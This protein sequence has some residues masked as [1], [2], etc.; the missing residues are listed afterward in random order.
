MYDEKK[1]FKHKTKS[2]NKQFKKMLPANLIKS[3][4]TT[5]TSLK[6]LD[7]SKFLNNILFLFINI[8]F[9]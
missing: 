6:C 5:D 4:A 7:T 9:I 3:K 2:K 8:T 1:L